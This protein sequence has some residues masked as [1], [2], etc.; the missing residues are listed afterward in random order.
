MSGNTGG[1]R[2]APLGILD[3]FRNIGKAKHQQTIVTYASSA[4]NCITG[5]Q[6]GR[7]GALSEVG[8]F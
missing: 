3:P 8:L 2:A 6:K 4:Y 5:G 7:T 1:M